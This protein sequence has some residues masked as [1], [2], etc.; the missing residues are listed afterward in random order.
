MDTICP[1]YHFLKKEGKFLLDSSVYYSYET[2][3]ISKAVFFFVPGQPE[4]RNL[5]AGWTEQLFPAEVTLAMHLTENQKER[6]VGIMLSILAS[7]LFA[8]AE[9]FMSDEDEE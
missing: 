4:R 5:Y 3:S 1:S 9:N 8:V 2:A 7:L 6:L